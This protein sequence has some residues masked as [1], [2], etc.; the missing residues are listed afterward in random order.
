MQPTIEFSE[1]FAMLTVELDRGEAIL[2]ETGAMV[3]MQSVDI[4]SGLPRQQGMWNKVL[5][6]A[7]RVISGETFLLNTFRARTDGATVSLAPSLPGDIEIFELREGQSLF[8]QS[9]SFLACSDNIITDTDFQGFKGFFSGEGI[10]FL[11]AICS[12]GI[13]QV[14]INSYGSVKRLQLTAGQP[15]LVIDTGHL[16]AFSDGIDYRVDKVGGI[17]S[18][19][20]GGEGLVMKFRGQ[21]EIWLQTHNMEA[22][23]DKIIPFLPTLSRN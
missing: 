21:G 4:S 22:L 13:G 7:K 23:A 9:G 11:Q 15:E 6:G 2:A 3:S 1:S 12:E 5:S 8:I 20:L 17:R 14:F 19:I 16:V 18:T 10:F